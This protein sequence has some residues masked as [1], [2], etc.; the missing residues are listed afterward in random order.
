MEKRIAG[1]RTGDPL[2]LH[3]QSELK[4]IAIIYTSV[5]KYNKAYFK[6]V[7]KVYVTVYSLI[8]FRE[9]MLLY[10]KKGKKQGIREKKTI[11]ISCEKDR[12]KGIR[13]HC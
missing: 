11:G 5:L 4:F 12:R 7:S 3:I 10:Q 13:E 2:F 8:T 1:K 6:K 9:S